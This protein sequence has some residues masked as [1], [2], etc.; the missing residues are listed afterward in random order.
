MDSIL[1]K[2]LPRLLIAAAVVLLLASPIFAKDVAYCSGRDNYAVKVKGLDINP[3]PVER[4][5]PAT[6]SISATTEEPITG[7]KLLI[8]VSYFGIHIH[9]ET[10]DLCTETT[11]PASGDFVLEHSQSLPGFTPPGNYWLTMKMIS[12]QGKQLTCINFGFSIG[13][14]SSVAAD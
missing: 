12:P 13:F 8:E 5:K 14:A 7:G 3:D 2:S 1:I 11:C 4:G 9:S 10:H 6:F